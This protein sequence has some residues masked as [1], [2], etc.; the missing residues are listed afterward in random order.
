MLKYFLCN[1]AYIS[2]EFSMSY[3]L[4]IYSFLNFSNNAILLGLCFHSK[5]NTNKN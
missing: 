4:N 1:K 2:V 3:V 5:N